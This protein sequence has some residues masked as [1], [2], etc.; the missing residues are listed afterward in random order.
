MISRVLAGTAPAATG[1]AGAAAGGFA[2]VVD[3]VFA[4]AAVAAPLPP[5][6]LAGSR[7]VD[8]GSEPP[9]SLRTG[10][11]AAGKRLRLNTNH[12]AWPRRKKKG[13]K[14]E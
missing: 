8:G 2:A 12:E 11:R 4:F 7:G 3:G 1:L 5:A 14:N 13:R 10:T 9:A 6:G